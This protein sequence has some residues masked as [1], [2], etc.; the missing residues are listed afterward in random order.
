MLLGGMDGGGTRK[1]RR[2]K[3]DEKL[4]ANSLRAKTPTCPLPGAAND[5]LT[6]CASHYAIYMQV[7]GKLLL[8]QNRITSLWQQKWAK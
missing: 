7:V 8:I 2:E 5:F 3:G 4:E 6:S 1:G